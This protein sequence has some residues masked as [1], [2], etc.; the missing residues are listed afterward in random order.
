MLYHVFVGER[1]TDK[2][3][4]VISD[5]NVIINLQPDSGSYNALRTIT[6]TITTSETDDI[7]VF[8]LIKPFIE[9]QAFINPLV[10]YMK[11]EALV[12]PDM[13]DNHVINTTNGRVIVPYISYQYHYFNGKFIGFFVIEDSG[14]R[15]AYGLPDGYDIRDFNQDTL[16]QEI[17]YDIRD[18][19]CNF[20][21]HP[22]LY[23]MGSRTGN[24]LTIP[25]TYKFSTKSVSISTSNKLIVASENSINQ[26]SMTIPVGE[27]KTIL[28]VDSS[29]VYNTIDLTYPA[30]EA[31]INY[32]NGYYNYDY[33]DRITVI[34]DELGPIS[35]KIR[36]A[37][38][39]F[40]SR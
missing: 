15:T 27:S 40:V 20:I 24:T 28:L 2:P 22:Y 5:T 3:P 21:D 18:Q 38:S 37:Q 9:E 6:G 14:F 34:E 7:K 10:N 35:E 26:T 23:W 31:K 19:G 39:I 17:T 36:D 30:H 11:I 16:I 32:G 33:G 8:G 29:D 25:V 12:L 4:T 13:F 1:I